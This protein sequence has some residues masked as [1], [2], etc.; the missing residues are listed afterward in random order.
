MKNGQTEV[1]KILMQAKGL[2]LGATYDNGKTLLSIACE[3]QKTDIVAILLK[4]SSVKINQPDNDGK[5]AFLLPVFAK[6]CQDGNVELFEFLHGQPGI[7]RGIASEDMV[8][9]FEAA[10]Q[11]S[12]AE[13]VRA[14]LSSPRITIDPEVV[15][16][17]L[18]EACQ[19]DNTDLVAAFLD[20]RRDGPLAYRTSGDQSE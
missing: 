15:N 13:F 8:K 7:E 9:F 18:S 3:R 2:N 6:A 10:C 19:G 1:V 11:R 12:N 20:S 14:V 17:A 16:D 4:H 5:T